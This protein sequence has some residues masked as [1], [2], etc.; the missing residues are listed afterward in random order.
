ME[1]KNIGM[2]IGGGPND[3]E[4]KAPIKRSVEPHFDALARCFSKVE[5]TSKGG[6]VSLDLKI[7][8]KGGKAALQKYKSG[9]KGD[10]FKACVETVFAGIDFEKPKT[11]ATVVSYSLRFTPKKK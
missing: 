9:I 2:H 6:D 3:A 7:D 4:T 8:A 10:A 1:V 11:G 5:D